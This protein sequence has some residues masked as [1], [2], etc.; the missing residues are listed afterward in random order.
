MLAP[1]RRPPELAGCLDELTDLG[2]RLFAQDKAFFYSA[3]VVEQVR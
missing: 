3:F 1:R 2:A